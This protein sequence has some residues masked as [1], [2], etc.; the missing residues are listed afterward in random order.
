MLI[1]TLINFITKCNYAFTSTVCIVSESLIFVD[2]QLYLSMKPDETNQLSKL[3]VCLKDMNIWMTRSFLLLNSDKTEV[4]VLG[5]QHLRNTL[6]NDILTLDGTALASSS[7][8]RNLG[9]VL[10]QDMFFNS[11]IK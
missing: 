5:P 7:T 10:D 11:H 9:V 4:I 1:L 8:A 3:Q 6:S 2:T